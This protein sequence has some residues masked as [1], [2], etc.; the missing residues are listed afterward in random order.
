M[1]IYNDL[2]KSNNFGDLL[3]QIDVLYNTLGY[4]KQGDVAHIISV[5]ITGPLIKVS[6]IFRNIVLKPL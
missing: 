3:Q 4:Y 1:R 6:Q 2:Q 5:L